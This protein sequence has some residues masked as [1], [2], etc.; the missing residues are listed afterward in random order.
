MV[1]PSPNP[2]HG[3]H[4]KDDIFG[5]FESVEMPAIINAGSFSSVCVDIEV[6]NLTINNILT[7]SLT[8]ELEG[9]R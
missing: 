8:N 9:G 1:V 4:E 5:S 2:D 7:S 3:G 6:Q